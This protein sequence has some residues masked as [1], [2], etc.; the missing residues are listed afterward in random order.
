MKGF[1]NTE[2][3]IEKGVSAPFGGVVNDYLIMAGGC[4]FPD[5][6]VFEGGKKHYYKGVYAANVAQ[7]N[8]L[9]WTKVGELPVEAGYG[10]S[11]PSPKGIYM[12]GGNNL[13]DRLKMLMKCCSTV[14]Q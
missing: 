1:P 10:V 14:K 8:C 3:G 4:N 2:N 11:I 13:E 6:P 5:K 12:L 7:G 9:S